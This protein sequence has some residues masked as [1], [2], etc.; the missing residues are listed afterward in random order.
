MVERKGPKVIVARNLAPVAPL[1]IYCL[2]GVIV[3]RV[4]IQCQCQGRLLEEEKRN[5]EGL[6][7]AHYR[8]EH[9]MYNLEER[10]EREMQ[11]VNREIHQLKVRLFFHTKIVLVIIH[12]FLSSN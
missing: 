10:F 3:Y 1:L 2:A 8:V 11:A 9:D 7:K 4:T 12:T 5:L 6:K